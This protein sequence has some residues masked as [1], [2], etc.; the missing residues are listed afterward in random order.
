MI[1]VASE[2]TRS[3]PLSPHLSV[4]KIEYS[5]I[6]SI[7]HRITGVILTLSLLGLGLIY[8]VQ[9]YKIE[10]LAAIVAKVNYIQ[11]DYPLVISGGVWFVIF[12]LVFM[13]AYHTS[14]GIRHLVWDSVI[15]TVSK[16]WVK[17]TSY[18]VLGLTVIIFIGL[19]ST[20]NSVV[21]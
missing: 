19:L 3:R 9:T 10:V 13:L 20:K 2:K 5:S 17:P 12:S 15:S 7:Y 14:N 11:L 4:Y 1:K 6:L 8:K 16:D 21:A 18:M